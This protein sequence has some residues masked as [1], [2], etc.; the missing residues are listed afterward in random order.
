MHQLN[1]MSRRVVKFN[2][3]INEKSLHILG[4]IKQNVIF[5]GKWPNFL[6]S[7]PVNRINNKVNKSVWLQLRR[8]KI[9]WNGCCQMI[10]KD[11]LW[12][13][14]RYPSPL[15]SGILTGFRY[16]SFQVANQLSSRGW[17]DPVADPILTGKFLG[18]SGDSNPGPLGW[19]SD[20]LTTI[21]NR[22]SFF[23][24]ML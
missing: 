3:H 15:I 23:F 19:Q 7:P 22:F 21:P 2:Q 20:V 5:L 8:A 13:A 6:P 9:D 16:F 18:H 24:V 1:K 10:V 4:K 17:V 14:H 12:L 11:T